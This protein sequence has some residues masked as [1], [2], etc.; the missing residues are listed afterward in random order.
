MKQRSY[1]ALVVVLIMVLLLGYV[2]SYLA[3]AVPSGWV[4]R[5]MSGEWHA[6]NVSYYRISGVERVF[7]PLEQID[8]KIRPG[9]WAVKPPISL[10][11]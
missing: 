7:W 9:A 11:Y 6:V 3:L 8:R 5:Y 10:G 1:A 2:G 4:F